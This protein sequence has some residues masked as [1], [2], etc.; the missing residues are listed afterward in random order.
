MRPGIEA[1][2]MFR[3]VQVR[4]RTAIGQDPWLGFSTLAEVHFAGVPPLTAQ[5]DRSEMERA[6][7]FIKETEDQSRLEAFISQFGDSP[8]AEM[9]RARLQELR[10]KQVAVA[11]PPKVPP[12]SQPSPAPS[13]SPPTPSHVSPARPAGAGQ[14][15]PEQVAVSAPPANMVQEKSRAGFRRSANRRISGATI[16]SY[17]Q[18]DT[19]DQCERQCTSVRGCIAYEH[20]IGLRACN[21]FEFVN[22]LI[23]GEG[24]HAGDRASASPADPAGAG[25]KKPEQVAVPTPP[26]NMAPEKS[27]AG[28]RR[29]A[30]R[31]ISGATIGSYPQIG[32]EDQCERQCTSVRGCIALN[33]ILDYVRAIHLSSSIA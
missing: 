33:T 29:S 21:T 13:A 11:T 30:N 1:V 5:P 31:R 7:T 12:P 2:T 16:G 8:Y 6:W 15:K 4:V 26:A 9:A 25:Q 17:S 20:H 23:V 19:E 18:I 22:R 24:W 28:F 10:K 3:R 14:K 27:G 32:T